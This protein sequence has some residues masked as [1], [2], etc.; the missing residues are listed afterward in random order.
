MSTSYRFLG[1]ISKNKLLEAVEKVGLKVHTAP[2][3][4]F[5]N[6]CITNGATYI[7]FYNTD[8]EVILSADRYG[9]NYDAQETILDV[10][11]KELEIGYLSEYDEGFYEEEE[12]V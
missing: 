8:D 10:L 5:N 11:S 9:G 2:G 12:Y 7:W 3:V 4:D 6:T 1:D